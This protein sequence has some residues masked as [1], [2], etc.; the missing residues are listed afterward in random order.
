MSQYLLYTGGSIGFSGEEAL[1]FMADPT[2][3]I[4]WAGSTRA[5]WPPGPWDHEPDFAC[6]ELEAPHP[7]MFGAV[8]RHTERGHWCGYI[9]LNSATQPPMPSFLDTLGGFSEEITY[10]NCK[11]E[12]NSWRIL[13]YFGK[14]PAR[15]YG[16]DKDHLHDK[17]P[18]DPNA[19]GRYTTFARVKALVQEL[20]KICVARLPEELR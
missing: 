14:S 16:F 6:F 12:G 18:S 5:R 1:R 13:R 4:R 17:A 9:C 2:L 19:G 11:I 10:E 15:I 3:P 7:L 8:S 20:G